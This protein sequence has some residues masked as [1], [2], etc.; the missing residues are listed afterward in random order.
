MKKLCYVLAY[1]IVACTQFG[2][3]GQDGGSSPILSPPSEA[4]KLST[5]PQY[6]VDPLD[7][8]QKRNNDELLPSYVI[9]TKS[10]CYNTQGTGLVINLTKETDKITVRNDL[11]FSPVIITTA[12][13]VNDSGETVSN[14]DAGIKIDFHPNHH[15]SFNIATNRALYTAPMRIKVSYQRVDNTVGDIT[16][17]VAAPEVRSLNELKEELKQMKGEGVSNENVGIYIPRFSEGEQALLTANGL[18]SELQDCKSNRK[19]YISRW[20]TKQNKGWY[21]PGTDS[22]AYPESEDALDEITN[23]YRAEP[24]LPQDFSDNQIW[25]LLIIE[26]L[27]NE[28]RT[29][30]LKR[31]TSCYERYVQANPSESWYDEL[32]VQYQ[33]SLNYYKNLETLPDSAIY[34]LAVKEIEYDGSYH[35]YPYVGELLRSGDFISTLVTMMNGENKKEALKDLAEYFV[36]YNTDGAVLNGDTIFYKIV[37]SVATAKGIDF[38][39]YINMERLCHFKSRD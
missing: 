9:C 24:S 8:P 27:I 14:E 26:E 33:K 31:A 29:V 6:P 32:R 16:A 3:G 30:Y 19:E 17:V 5:T 34:P 10:K 22:T 23:K 20:R 12:N 35:K 21:G 36:G 13:F 4:S 11:N 1:V 25:Q 39:N 37:D 38:I 7:P 15:Y 2:C 28:Y 18:T